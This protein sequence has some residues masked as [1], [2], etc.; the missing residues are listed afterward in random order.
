MV[1]ATGAM[2]GGAQARHIRIHH[3]NLFEA[4]LRGADLSQAMLNACTLEKAN[5]DDCDLSGSYLVYSTCV[6]AGFRHAQ[7]EGLTALGSTFREADFDGAMGF[8]RCNEIVA[9]VLLREAGDEHQRIMECAAIVA[10]RERCY[11]EWKEYLADHADAEAFAYRV[12]GHY[13]ESGCTEAL[14]DA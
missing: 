8:F 14:R 7:L 5:L 12:F 4:D 3:V 13:P 10:D 9:E 6:G 11:P 2:L 1:T